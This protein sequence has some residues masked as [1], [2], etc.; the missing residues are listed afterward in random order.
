MSGDSD[1]DDIRALLGLEQQPKE[2][3]T[4]F[5]QAVAAT[6]GQ[7]LESL[8]ASGM[9]EVDEG[10]LPALTNEV[11]EAALESHSLKKLPRRI[12]KTLIHSELVEE[13]YGTDEEIGTALQPF[14]DRL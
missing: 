8:A 5:A 14:L 1:L 13:V 7:A 6:L 11:V 4:E 2:E 12:V 9:V 10:K 3:P